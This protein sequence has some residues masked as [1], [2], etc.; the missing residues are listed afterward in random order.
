MST[1]E[2]AVT[3]VGL[4]DAATMRAIHDVERAALTELRVDPDVPGWGNQGNTAVARP[5]RG[6]LL[7]LLVKAALMQWL[8]DAEPC[9]R[10]VVTYNSAAN[11]H[12]IAINEELGYEVSGVPYL[13]TQVPVSGIS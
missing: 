5:H 11:S 1:T 3:R 13:E 7:G 10:K 4:A 8:A 6:H 2:Q 12:M 9:V